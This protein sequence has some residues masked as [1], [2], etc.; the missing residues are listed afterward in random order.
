MNQKTFFITLGL[1]LALVAIS[2]SPIRH[3]GIP[4]AAEDDYYYAWRAVTAKCG[5]DVQLLG[6]FMVKGST[7]YAF[8]HGTCG[9]GSANEYVAVSYDLRTHSIG[10]PGIGDFGHNSIFG[11]IPISLSDWKINSQDA[12]QI[13]STHGLHLTDF[14]PNEIIDMQGISGSLELY[15]AGQFLEWLYLYVNRADV[16]EIH[17]NATTG[18][19]ISSSTRTVGIP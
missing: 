7:N 1:V 3:S 12:F 18:Q 11:N 15:Q 16:Y 13:V 19:V 8:T 9:T 14:L 5:P 2:L 10:N 4:P 17:I 6:I